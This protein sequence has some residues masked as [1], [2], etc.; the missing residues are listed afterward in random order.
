MVWFGFLVQS[1]VARMAGLASLYTWEQEPHHIIQNK[2]PP[3]PRVTCFPRGGWIM[4]K[5]LEAPWEPGDWAG[6]SYL[7]TER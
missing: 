3:G 4:D 2:N 7:R 5:H 1:A 6:L